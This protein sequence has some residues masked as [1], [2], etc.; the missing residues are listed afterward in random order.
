[1]YIIA[2]DIGGTNIR[3]AIADQHS[4]LIEVKKEA[5]LRHDKD[6]FIAQVIGIITQL[7][8]N[9]Y[10]P[11]AI[12]IGVPGRVRSNGFIDELPNIGIQAIDLVKPLNKMFN[13]PVTIKNDAEMA[14]F[15]EA[16]AGAGKAY[17]STYFVTISTGIGGCLI[18]NH[19]IK[20]PSGEIGHTLV[21]YKDGF[22][23]LEKIASGDGVL[24]LAALNNIYYP[25]GKAFFDDVEKGTP[26]ALKIFDE[27]LTLIADFFSYIDEAF[28]PDVIAVTGGVLKSKHLF[29][30]KLKAL[31]PHAN[32]VIAKFSEDAGL[33]GAASYGLINYGK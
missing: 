16:Y 24:K 18:D 10:D 12:S 19:Q 13:L 15:A 26:Y 27:W 25:T 17:K 23:E 30:D 8:L 6:L 11:V 7:N 31:V 32:I 9:K 20:N 2:L 21:P 14:A 1:M 3:A 33:V 4:T 28:T 29:W 5:T 22:Y